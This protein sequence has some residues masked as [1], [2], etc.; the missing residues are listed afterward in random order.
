MS[1]KNKCVY[2]FAFLC[3]NIYHLFIIKVIS[4]LNISAC[5][6]LKIFFMF[7]YKCMHVFSKTMCIFKYKC[8]HV[9]ARGYGIFAEYGAHLRAHTVSIGRVL[10]FPLA[11]SNEHRLH[12]ITR[13]IGRSNYC[14]C[15][16]N[17]SL[18]THFL[19]IFDLKSNKY[20]QL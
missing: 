11:H 19:Q 16:R 9:Y 13:F 15:E 6:F 17:E 18:N 1:L 4:S 3:Q 20:A 7:E 8:M 10:Y 5:I 2:K 14:V 12:I